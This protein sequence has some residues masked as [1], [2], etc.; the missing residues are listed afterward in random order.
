VP[1]CVS[2]PLEHESIAV[3]TDIEPHDIINP[4][5]PETD[6]EETALKVFFEMEVSLNRLDVDYSRMQ[7]LQA[8]KNSGPLKTKKPRTLKGPWRRALLIWTPSSIGQ[9]LKLYTN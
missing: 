2:K 3:Q 8:C 6:N 5:T 4:D 9:M 1:I 7:R